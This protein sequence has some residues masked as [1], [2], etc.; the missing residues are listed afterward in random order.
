MTRFAS[1]TTLATI[2]AMGFAGSV[3]AKAH[4]QGVADGQP[5]T[6]APGA[7]AGAVDDAVKGGQRGAAA[8]DAKGDNRK[9]PTVG[10]G[11]N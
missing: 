10:N 6:V 2:A 8:S 9:T 1:F 4:D 5:N 7:A 11:K 3:H